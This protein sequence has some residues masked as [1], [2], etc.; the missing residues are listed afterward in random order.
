[1][2][3]VCYVQNVWNIIC[4]SDAVIEWVRLIFKNVYL[5]NFYMT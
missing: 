5:E 2:C 4:Y 1:M 3:L